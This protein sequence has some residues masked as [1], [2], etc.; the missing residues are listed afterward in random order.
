MRRFIIKYGVFTVLAVMLIGIAWMAN[1]YHINQK[2]EITIIRLGD[3]GDKSTALYKAYTA[4]NPS[5]SFSK[6]DTLRVSQTP[7]GDL[8]FIIIGAQREP[9]S[10]VLYLI[11]PSVGNS[12]FTLGGNTMTT[13]FLTTGK[14]KIGKLILQKLLAR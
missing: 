2:Q 13:G 5:L 7:Y 11:P 14:E 8:P 6:D 4:F 1:T 3:Y 12:D 10:L 9:S